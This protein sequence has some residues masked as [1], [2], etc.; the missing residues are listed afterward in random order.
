[1][2]RQ[3]A[4]C[5][6][7]IIFK[8]VYSYMKWEKHYRYYEMLPGV[9][10]WS[11]FCFGIILSFIKPLWVIYFILAFSLLWLFRVLYFVFYIS[12]SWQKYRKAIKAD[13]MGKIKKIKNWNRLYH[14]VVIPTATEPF[15]VLDTTLGGL[16]NSDYPIDKMIVIVSGEERCGVDRFNK[17]TDK[18]NIK[19]KDKF[20]K[21][22]F[23]IHPGD[24]PN[25]VKGKSANAYWAGH[26]CK[27][28][29]DKE[30]IPYEDIV[31]SYFDSDTTVHPKYFS[32]LTY[33]YLTHP[34]P[35]RSSYQP[36]VLYS[37]NIFLIV[38]TLT[39]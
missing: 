10:V 6:C 3:G 29:I 25:E 36:M 21:I 16:V 35:T 23:T 34:N 38:I 8:I 27:E 20:Y 19:Y 7:I 2:Q 17:I 30:G 1:M 26:R 22:I 32:H 4:I 14:L 13:W 37:N 11:T 24:L 12:I 15:E 31:V 39:L 28:F 5:F 33:L 9:L 18:L